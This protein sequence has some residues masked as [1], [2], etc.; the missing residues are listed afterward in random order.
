MRLEGGQIYT[1]SS[2]W[3]AGG[4]VPGDIIWHSCYLLTNDALC[5]PVQGRGWKTGAG[6][7]C[8]AQQESAFNSLHPCSLLLLHV[9]V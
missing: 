8:W 2:E 4:A 9:S 6:G 7:R 3:W 5:V 1:H